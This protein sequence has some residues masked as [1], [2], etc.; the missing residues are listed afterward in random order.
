MSGPERLAE[1]ISLDDVRGP[2]AVLCCVCGLCGDEHVASLQ[3]E[4]DGTFR[5][6]GLQCPKCGQM[7]CVAIDFYRPILER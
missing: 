1:V 2:W 5:Q 4:R 3:G 7:S 6:F